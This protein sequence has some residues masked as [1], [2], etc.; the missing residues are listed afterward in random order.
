M[1][2]IQRSDVVA[3]SII[4]ALNKVN[5]SYEFNGN[6]RF[7]IPVYSRKLNETLEFEIILAENYYVTKMN[8]YI[9]DISDDAVPYLL[10]ILNKINL[11]SGLTRFV[12]DKNS[13]YVLHKSVTFCYAHKP[14]H[15]RTV[16][17]NILFVVLAAEK[18]FQNLVA[19]NVE[20]KGITCN[21]FG[22]IVNGGEGLLN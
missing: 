19:V 18:C 7:L 6:D 17:S 2:I 21:G 12:L 20:Y 14:S 22:T 8:Y 11:S 13:K 15:W 1:N 10:D 4:A 5:Y 9:G 16:S 3:D